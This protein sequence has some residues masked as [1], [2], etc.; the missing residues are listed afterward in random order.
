MLV[1]VAFWRPSG[2][3]QRGTGLQRAHAISSKSGDLM[4]WDD[5]SDALYP[6]VCGHD[7]ATVPKR[8]VPNLPVPW[9]FMGSFGETTPGHLL[10]ALPQDL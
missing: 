5:K 7:T 1:A 6:A 10:V 9:G 4:P 8:A 3:E 2:P